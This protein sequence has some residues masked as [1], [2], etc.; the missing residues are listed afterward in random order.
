MLDTPLAKKE[1]D[2]SPMVESRPMRLLV[3]DDNELD[4]QRLLRLCRQAGLNFEATEVAATVDLAAKLA[5]TSYDTVSIDYYL[6]GDTGLDALEILKR[7]PDQKGAAAIMLAGE[8]QLSVAVEAMRQGCSDYLTKAMM[9]VETLQKSIATALERQIMRAEM[10]EERRARLNVERSILAY[11]SA[12]TNEMRSILA[13]TL[14][15][16]R[17]MRGYQA[18]STVDF[19]LD[20]SSLEAEIDRLWEA[21]PDFNEVDKLA[22][23]PTKLIGGP[24]KTKH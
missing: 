13:G 6:S 7:H 19:S 17:K 3:I 4:R 16:V 23:V 11:A 5:I 15:R 14:R 1:T 24:D 9:N 21:M 22:P 18:A 8:G 2:P 10:R 12:C 20:L